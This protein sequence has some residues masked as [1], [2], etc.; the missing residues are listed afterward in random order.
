MSLGEHKIRHQVCL[1]QCDPCWKKYEILW[2]IKSKATS[3]SGLES[4]PVVLQQISTVPNIV[5][6]S[7]QRCL[8]GQKTEIYILQRCEYVN[9]DHFVMEA[10]TS[11]LKQHVKNEL[12]ISTHHIYYERIN[13][14][15]S[16]KTHAN[17][18]TVQ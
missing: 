4:E 13:E 16:I 7:Q 14:F 17:T 15:D 11:G 2:I 18:A 1:R 10:V 8:R 5:A 3:L 9:R 12:H 6:K